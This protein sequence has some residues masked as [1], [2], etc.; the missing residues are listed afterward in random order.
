M[1]DFSTALGFDVIIVGAGPAGLAVAYRLLADAPARIGRPLSLCV[2]EKSARVGGHLLSGALVTADIFAWLACPEADYPD[3]PVVDQEARYWLTGRGALPLPTMAAWRHSGK[4]ILSLPRLCR[5]LAQRVEQLGGVIFPGFAAQQ[6][7]FV[8]EQLVGVATGVHGND[9]DGT[10]LTAP[11]TV[12]AEGCRGFLSQQL[13]D[14]YQLDHGRCP[15]SYGLGFREVWQVRHSQPGMVLHT[16]GWPLPSD[17]YGGGFAYH[18]DSQHVAVGLVVG[19]DYR[20]PHWR[21]FSAFQRWKSHPLIRSYLDGGQLLSYG[22]RSLVEGGWHSLPRL[23]VNGGLLVGDAAGFFDGPPLRGVANAIQSGVLAAST[24]L[25]ALAAEDYSSHRLQPYTQAVIH[26]EIGRGL[27]RHRNVRP[28]FRIHV[29]LGLVNAAWE[30]WT[31]GRSPWHWRWHQSDRQRLRLLSPHLPTPSSIKEFDCAT[32]LAYSGLR[33]FPQ[34]SHLHVSAERRRRCD[35]G[36]PELY[37]CPA[38][39]FVRQQ[40]GEL[41]VRAENCLHCKCCDIKDPLNGIR[42]T[43]PVGGSGPDYRDL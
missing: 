29:G 27:W 6:L 30:G 24:L 8:G 25:D 28:G 22:A 11:V 32:A 35:D 20:D 39:V 42:W 41:V 3:F 18:L 33:Y 31:G 9:H 12:L 7:L 16:M 34:P 38:E 10:I 37:Y 14:R 15:Q 5:W 17:C 40:D 1:T 26:S 4:R 19:L 13:I 23:V 2:L 36:T 43:P 21:P